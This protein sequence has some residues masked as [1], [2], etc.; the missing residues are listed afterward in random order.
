MIAK[1]LLTLAVFFFGNI[2]DALLLFS[3]W[4]VVC[5]ETFF[6]HCL[7]VAPWSDIIGSASC[8][9]SIGRARLRLEVA[10]LKMR[11]RTWAQRLAAGTFSSNAR[12]FINLF[13]CT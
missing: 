9:L 1:G 4:L 5:R 12:W 13:L 6:T 11:Q 3:S 2:E 10:F 7:L 8:M